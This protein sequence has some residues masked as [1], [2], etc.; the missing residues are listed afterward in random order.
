MSLQEIGSE[1][2]DIAKTLVKVEGAQKVIGFHWSRTDSEASDW[3]RIR[4]IYPEWSGKRA[5]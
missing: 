3:I 5:E 4:I 2:H 1:M